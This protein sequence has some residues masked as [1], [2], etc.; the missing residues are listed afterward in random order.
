MYS[1]GD[2]IRLDDSGALK[3]DDGEWRVDLITG[4]LTH[5]PTAVAFRVESC[6]VGTTKQHS[7]YVVVPWGGQLPPE[8][9]LIDLG[10]MAE[11]LYFAAVEY[12]EPKKPKDLRGQEL[13]DGPG[14]F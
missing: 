10:K 5:L 2:R 1:E 8:K 4:M 7:V 13:K 6:L 11:L 9:E 3:L 14:F 12:M